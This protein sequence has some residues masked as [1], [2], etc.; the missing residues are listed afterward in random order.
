MSFR[1][2]ERTMIP[3]LLGPNAAVHGEHVALS[4]TPQTKPGR[5]YRVHDY[6]NGRDVGEIDRQ[7]LSWM[8]SLWA[9]CC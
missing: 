9:A 3:A 7:A 8:P 5:K 4:D 1:A 6:V 2:G